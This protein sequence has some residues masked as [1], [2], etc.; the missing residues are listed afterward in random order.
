MNCPCCGNPMEEGVLSSRSPV[1]WSRQNT[2]LPFP[3]C[4]DDVILGKALGLLCP[5]AHL[6]RGCRKV[7]VEY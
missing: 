2:G 6:C 3:T 5:K 7:I 4:G 1:L